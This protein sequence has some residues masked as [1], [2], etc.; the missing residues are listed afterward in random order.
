[1]NPETVLKKVGLI[2]LKPD[3]IRLGL[4]TPLLHD[5]IQVGLTPH[6]HQL[7]YLTKG[8]VRQ[9]YPNL[10]DRPGLY[11]VNEEY[12]TSG[13]SMITLVTNGQSG[14]DDITQY[15]EMVKGK[16]DTRGLRR[17]Y[18]NF[19]PMEELINRFGNETDALRYAVQNRIHSP[20]DAT[21][22]YDQLSGLWSRLD[23]IKIRQMLPDLF[24]MFQKEVSY[25]HS[26]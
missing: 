25:A 6:Y 18:M 8:D 24:K 23:H 4:D 7:L 5:L 22:A 14:Y 16:A 21:E 10:L 9:I 19:I 1:M 2:I 17:K 13:Q 20:N 12:M 26:R 15:I 3:A 11:K